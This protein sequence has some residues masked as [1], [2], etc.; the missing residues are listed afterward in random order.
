MT[1]VIKE[2]TNTETV[3]NDKQTID[4]EDKY[5]RNNQISCFLNCMNILHYALFQ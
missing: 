5:N 4:I 1:D 3:N 2:I